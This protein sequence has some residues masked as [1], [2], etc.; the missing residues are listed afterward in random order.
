MGAEVAK[1]KKKESDE[2]RGGTGS[3]TAISANKGSVSK[4]WIEETQGEKKL[5]D[6]KENLGEKKEL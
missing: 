5:L 6:G 1:K 2:K 3:A 4:K